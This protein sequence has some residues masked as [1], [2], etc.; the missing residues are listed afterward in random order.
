MNIIPIDGEI[1]DKFI[2]KNSGFVKLAIPP[3]SFKH[4]DYPVDTLGSMTCIVAGPQVPENVIYKLTKYTWEH[5]QDVID[6]HSVYKQ[7][8]EE[9]VPKGRTVPWHPGAEKFWKEVGVIK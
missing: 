4:Q 2:A 5:R 6:A 7:F 8:T 3:N 9:T 1:S